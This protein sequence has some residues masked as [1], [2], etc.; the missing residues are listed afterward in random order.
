MSF[1]WSLEHLLGLYL[2]T[3]GPGTASNSGVQLGLSD[4]VNVTK[5]PA[6]VVV[7]EG[8][9]NASIGGLVVDTDVD[10]IAIGEGES[11]DRR[12]VQD[13]SH[14]DKVRNFLTYLKVQGR[15]KV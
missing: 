10:T 2:C 15:R 3:V 11:S 14:F 9:L 8:L 7:V 12:T 5:S 4:N 1:L 13:G 6:S